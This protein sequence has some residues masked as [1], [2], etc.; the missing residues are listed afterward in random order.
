MAKDDTVC[1]A[2]WPEKSQDRE[3]KFPYGLHIVKKMLKGSV[4]QPFKFYLSCRFKSTTIYLSS[5][6]VADTRTPLV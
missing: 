2:A 6:R 4:V 5:V 3:S 1:S